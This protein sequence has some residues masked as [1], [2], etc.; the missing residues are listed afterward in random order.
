MTAIHITFS[1]PPDEHDWPPAAYERVWAEEVSTNSARIDN[2]P[3]FTRE[4]TLGDV[5]EYR[6][7]PDGARA[8]L[9]VL[10][11]SASSLVRVLL[12]DRRDFDIVQARLIEMGCVVEGHVGR[13]ML[14]VSIPS[15][16]DIQDPMNYLVEM[17]DLRKLEYEEAIIRL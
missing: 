14:A 5:V 9:Q 13:L 7:E 3:F 6:L 17:E 2:V 8:F 16:I 12:L 1:T 4:A 10:M 11:P 15:T